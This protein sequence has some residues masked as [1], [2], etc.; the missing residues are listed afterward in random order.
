MT[1]SYFSEKLSS[2]DMHFLQSQTLNTLNVEFEM[3]GGDYTTENKNN[4]PI[5]HI[6][7]K[8][9]TTVVKFSHWVSSF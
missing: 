1:T 3:K 5:N 4:L 8:T 9:R 6:P 2:K 7:R